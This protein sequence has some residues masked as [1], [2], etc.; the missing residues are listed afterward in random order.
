V[1]TYSPGGTKAI[2]VYGVAS[3][4]L[5]LD[6]KQNKNNFY[7]LKLL[8]VLLLHAF[9]LH[10]SNHNGFADIWQH[11]TSIPYLQGIKSLLY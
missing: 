10:T 7:T 2:V 4:C 6:Y 1:K 8:V 11:V 5:T 3:N 9:L